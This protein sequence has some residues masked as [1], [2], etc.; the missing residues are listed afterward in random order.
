M[1]KNFK[2]IFSI[3]IAILLVLL[4]SIPF[5]SAATLLD[6]SQA[7]SITMNC[8]KPGYTFNVYKVATLDSTNT[9]SYETSYN[10]LIPEIS[11]K[12]LSGKT[13]DIL[14]ALDKIENM[15]SSAPTVDTFTTSSTS[16]TKTVSG[17]TQGIYY[18]RAVKYPAGVK[19]I[20]NSVV[21][22]PYY[23]DGWVYS[24]PAINLAEKVVITRIQ[25]NKVDEDNNAL[26]NCLLQIIDKDG[27][28]ID[29]WKTDGQP[30][31]IDGILS[32]G[33][34]YTLH[35]KV[36]AEGYDCAQDITFT[37][38][39]TSELQM[40]TMVDEYK[41]DVDIS[42]PDIPIRDDSSNEGGF[43][44]TGQTAAISILAI[45]IMIAAFVLYTIRKKKNEIEQ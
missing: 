44:K 1:Q 35:E 26:K 27:K 20:T 7:V 24:I 8:T 25:I 4:S 34:T 21:A 10:S 17:L 39:D 42:T 14:A 32:A 38:K 6:E 5:A 16:T 28:I 36:A 45:A 31:N 13:A 40:I 23:N 41:G 30:H 11:D 19:S 2:R 15:P 29:E 37:V 43:I 18:I 22:L 12:I 3:T 9:S 33:E